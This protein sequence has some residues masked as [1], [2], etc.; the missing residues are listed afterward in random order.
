[1]LW[2]FSRWNLW[3]MPAQL[4]FV[5]FVPCFLFAALWHVLPV[6]SRTPIFYQEP[7]L[8][9]I[10]VFF[11]IASAF[12]FAEAALR[13]QGK[14]T[15]LYTAPIST[16]SLVAWF[17][18]PACILVGLETAILLWVSNRLFQTP[19]PIVGPALFAAAL[20][21]SLRLLFHPQA[22]KSWLCLSFVIGLGSMQSLW[23]C[24]QYGGLPR[25]KYYWKDLTSLDVLVLIGFSLIAYAGTVWWVAQ[26]RCGEA[27]RAFQWRAA[28][29]RVMGFWSASSFRLTQISSASHAQFWYEKR[30]NL[31]KG[32]PFGVAVGL[33]LF[34]CGAILEGIS[35]Q[36]SAEFS[37][38]MYD[39]LFIFCGWI[40]VLGSIFG[41]GSGLS[42]YVPHRRR[43][44]PSARQVF[45][46][47]GIGGMGG[48]QS[49][50]PLQANQFSSAIFKLI[51]LNLLKSWTMWLIGLLLL[52]AVAA[53]L[54]VSLD[55]IPQDLRGTSFLPVA[56]ALSWILASNFSVVGM[57]GRTWLTLLVVFGFIA[58]MVIFFVV[59]ANLS[60]EA[61]ELLFTGSYLGFTLVSVTLF[62]WAY[63]RAIKS[64]MIDMQALVW[65][66]IVG[67]LIVFGAIALTPFE[68]RLFPILSLINLIAFS[69]LPW[70]T[71][72]LAIAWNRHR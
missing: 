30:R 40:V 31:I 38:K 18:V 7:S 45:L 68:W 3:L 2:Q 48:F 69:G 1:M 46:G 9:T 12:G 34:G 53:G 57:T 25:M 61:Q 47:E 11:L 27:G 70:S 62:V 21:T 50:L 36:P 24:S 64:A 39:M 35:E 32:L 16:A 58:A 22:T 56:L 51:A 17:T 44:E 14:M 59:Q 63:S 4:V 52:H 67:L 6:D 66:L 10:H 72:P 37:Q 41:L 29:E 71:A 33:V 54:S 42:D 43:E 13:L 5:G 26:D 15:R 28:W 49:T 19:F 55:F 8:I 20:T 23:L 65:P 60:P